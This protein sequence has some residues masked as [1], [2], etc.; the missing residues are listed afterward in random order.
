MWKWIWRKFTPRWKTYFSIIKKVEWT[1]GNVTVFTW[2]SFELWAKLGSGSNLYHRTMIFQNATFLHENS[3]MFA[4]FNARSIFRREINRLHT[5]YNYF[6]S[7]APRP[8][9]LF[10]RACNTSHNLLL[11]S[12]LSGTPSKRCSRAA[13]II[14]NTAHEHTF[15]ACPWVR[16]NT[17]IVRISSLLFSPLLPFF[18]SWRKIVFFSFYRWFACSYVINGK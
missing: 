3:L 1:R 13:E 12:Y 7:I 16:F 10:F 17:K 8:T 2:C 18:T 9:V 6:K 4:C 15:I 14:V 11:L 5:S